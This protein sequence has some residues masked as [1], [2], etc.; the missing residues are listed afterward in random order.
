VYFGDDDDCNNK[1]KW[2]CFADM[3]LTHQSRE[4]GRNSLIATKMGH[5]VQY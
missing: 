1:T 3:H 4:Y 2:V 5:A